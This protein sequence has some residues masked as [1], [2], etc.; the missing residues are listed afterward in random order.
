M[1][2][3][4]LS[5]LDLIP[6]GFILQKD[7]YTT[8]LLYANN[9]FPLKSLRERLPFLHPSQ[10]KKNLNYSVNNLRLNES[11]SNLDKNNNDLNYSARSKIK[12]LKKIL[13]MKYPI[14][15]G[16]M[17]SIKDLNFY[18][19]MSNKNI[20]VKNIDDDLNITSNKGKKILYKFKNT[21]SPI[22]PKLPLIPTKNYNNNN[23][24]KE[25]SLSMSMSSARLKNVIDHLNEDLKNI[26]IFEAKRKENIIRDKF[27]NTQIYVNN[28]I[29]RDCY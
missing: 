12:N 23:Q 17:M 26:K 13:K 29:H 19:E 8:N 20:R 7:V 22:M 27:F 15:K 14:P 21:K 11:T 28:I 3:N 10:E 25:K 5:K 24:N 4:L 1:S 2:Y 18:Q 6:T 9:Q 16:K